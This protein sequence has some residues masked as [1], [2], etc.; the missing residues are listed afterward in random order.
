MDQGDRFHPVK[1]FCFNLITDFS[2]GSQFF[3]AGA[4]QLFRLIFG[5][6]DGKGTSLAG[7]AFHG[8]LSAVGLGD[9]FDNG[10][11]QAGAAQLATAGFIDPIKSFKQ[12][13]Q[14][15]FGNANALVCNDDR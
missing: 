7:C 11:P 10:K 5:Q 3:V 2:Q 6:M 9:V 15:F 4:G 13:G 1:Y 14:V 8:Y 12:P